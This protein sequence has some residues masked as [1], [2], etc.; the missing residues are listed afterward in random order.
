M[1]HDWPCCENIDPLT[2]GGWGKADPGCLY[3]LGLTDPDGAG[4]PH[5]PGRL[6]HPQLPY[7]LYLG[8][9]VLR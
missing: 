6:E 7:H 5:P 2:L 3:G 4:P 9:G 8:P 1:A